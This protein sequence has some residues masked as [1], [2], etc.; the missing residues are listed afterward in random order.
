MKSQYR[1][2]TSHYQYKD[3][4]VLHQR[5]RGL[6][7]TN[8]DKLRTNDIANYLLGRYTTMYNA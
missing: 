1:T 8:V 3:Q 5:M 4:I 7:T 2:V 6:E